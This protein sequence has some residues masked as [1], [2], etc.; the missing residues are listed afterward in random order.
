M[1]EQVGS[2]PGANGFMPF[3]F[4]NIN[5]WVIGGPYRVFVKYKQ[6]TEQR[7]IIGV[8]MAQEL[9]NMPHDIYIGARDFSTPDMKAFRRGLMQS[10]A[11]MASGDQLYV[12]CMGG[13]GRTGLFLAG[14]AKIM[15]TEDP[16]GYVRMH[17]LSHAVETEEQQDFI[18]DLRVDDIQRWARMIA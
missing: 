15:G 8:L 3:Q 7:R 17:Y 1:N 5:G 18:T 13:I 10:I 11:R 16:V 6:R 12:G 2:L 9:S 4:S 14:L